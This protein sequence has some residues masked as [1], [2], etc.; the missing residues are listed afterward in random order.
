MTPQ[1]NCPKCGGRT[2]IA[3]S[4]AMSL[5]TREAYVECLNSE[6]RTALICLFYPNG[7]I[8]KPKDIAPPDQ[9]IQPKLYQQM[10]KFVNRINKPI[11]FR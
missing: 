11:E 5:T 4:K 2:R 10:E 8:R 3:T 1:I 7:V 6:C 9:A